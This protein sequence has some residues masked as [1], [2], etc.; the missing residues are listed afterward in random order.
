MMPD[1]QHNQGTC[2]SLLVALLNISNSEIA[3]KPRWEY[4]NGKGGLAIESAK[5]GFIESAIY[6]ALNS[7]L[8]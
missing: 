4:R 7:L 6:Q 2:D 8:Q 5:S 3:R 1:I